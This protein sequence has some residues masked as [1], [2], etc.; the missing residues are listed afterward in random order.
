MSQK[1]SSTGINERLKPVHGFP[2]F[3]GA[4]KTGPKLSFEQEVAQKRKLLHDSGNLQEPFIFDNPL[5][6]FCIKMLFREFK[7]LKGPIPLLFRQ[8][9]PTQDQEKLKVLLKRLLNK[10]INQHRL[11]YH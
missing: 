11:K 7:Y 2:H 4:A 6:R 8:P 1:K 3:V 10:K 5:S 9:Y